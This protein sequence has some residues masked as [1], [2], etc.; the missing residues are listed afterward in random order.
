MSILAHALAHRGH[1]D[2]AFPILERAQAHP[3]K[4]A[5]D[6]ERRQ[7]SPR[8]RSFVPRRHR[9]GGAHIPGRPSSTHPE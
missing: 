7:L 9:F 2:R 5:F 8:P 1:F 6:I 4:N 3:Q